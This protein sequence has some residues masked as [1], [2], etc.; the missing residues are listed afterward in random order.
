M[1]SLALKYIC[2]RT[3]EVYGTTYS[4]IL[5]DLGTSCGGPIDYPV[6]SRISEPLAC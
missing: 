5:R 3:I 4:D 2:Q 1:A 6:V